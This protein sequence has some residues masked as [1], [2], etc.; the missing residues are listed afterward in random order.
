MRVNAVKMGT[1]T[2]RFYS[3]QRFYF[4]ESWVVI[5]SWL[6]VKFDGRKKNNQPHLVLKLGL[7]LLLI[8]FI[9]NFT[10]FINDLLELKKLQIVILLFKCVFFLS[11]SWSLR[12]H[13]SILSFLNA[14]LGL[15]A[16]LVTSSEHEQRALIRCLL[17]E[18]NYTVVSLCTG[19]MTF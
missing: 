10:Q 17:L 13:I 11:L 12:S 18:H 5:G 7:L 6:L 14:V 3:W 4:T 19:A 2:R 15:C 1:M 16:G 8:S 9:W